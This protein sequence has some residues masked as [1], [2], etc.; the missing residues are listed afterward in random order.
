MTVCAHLY[1]LSL[2]RTLWCTRRR[3]L[4][5]V[6]LH[7][8]P[9]AGVA[10]LLGVSGGWG[11]SVPSP[12]PSAPPR[13]SVSLEGHS[14]GF[15]PQGQLFHSG[16]VGAPWRLTPS[17]HSLEIP[18]GFYA[19]PEASPPP[20]LRIPLQRTLRPGFPAGRQPSPFP[21][22]PPNGG[23]PLPL[24]P[25]PR[26]SCPMWCLRQPLHPLDQ[27]PRRFP[28]VPPMLTPT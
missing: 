15:F 13:H 1:P 8:L 11:V 27:F 17:S 3:C 25:I 16:G 5:L 19:T 6:A 9:A 24:R 12:P 21:V 10:A 26:R 7:L 20:P 2:C 22:F 28:P 4:I 14:G 18:L 23:P